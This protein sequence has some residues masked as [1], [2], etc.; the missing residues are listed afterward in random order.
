MGAFVGA[1]FPKKWLCAPYKG[2]PNDNTNR[3]AKRAK[4][5]MTGTAS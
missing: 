5:K 2:E 1:I 3:T 4:M